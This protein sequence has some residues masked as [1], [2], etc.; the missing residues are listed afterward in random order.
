MLKAAGFRD[1]RPLRGGLDAWRAA[2]YP[3]ESI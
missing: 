1:V 3:V 2:G